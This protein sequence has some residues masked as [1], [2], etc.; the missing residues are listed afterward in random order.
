MVGNLKRGC[1]LWRNRLK[2]ASVLTETVSLEWL[3]YIRR[4]KQQEGMSLYIAFLLIASKGYWVMLKLILYNINSLHQVSNSLLVFLSWT[5]V[6]LL[7]VVVINTVEVISGS[8]VSTVVW[9][10][11]RTNSTT[12]TDWVQHVWVWAG[13]SQFEHIQSPRADHT[14]RVDSL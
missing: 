4:L 12:M 8:I 11:L 9:L 5:G 2:L 10:L 14:H 6:Q 13:G 3:G 1:D 7:Q